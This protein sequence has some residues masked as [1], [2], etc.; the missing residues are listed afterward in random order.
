M[1]E[2]EKAGIMTKIVELLAPLA[3]EERMRILKAALALLG[4]NKGDLSVDQELDSTAGRLSVPQRA[5]AWMKQN[6]VSA[7]DIQQVFHISDGKVEVI[8]PEMPGTND[9]ER[10]HNAYVLKGI[11]N[12]LEKD[13]PTFTDDAARELCKSS[14]CLNA[15]NHAKFIDG[16]SNEFTGTKKGGWTLTAPGLKRGGSLV[17]ELAKKS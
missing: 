3:S 10:T 12:L 5:N 1:D 17:K 11:A 8:A 4:E 16:K 13:V 6:G 2:V 14:G 9:K 7:E 15:S